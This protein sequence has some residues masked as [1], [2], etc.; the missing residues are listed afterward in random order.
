MVDAL[1]VR[2]SCWFIKGDSENKNQ[3]SE[4]A[5]MYSD[6]SSFFGTL[7]GTLIKDANDFAMYFG[8]LMWRP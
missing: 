8:K 4:G 6:V 1:A 3:C 7:R 2:F 5:F